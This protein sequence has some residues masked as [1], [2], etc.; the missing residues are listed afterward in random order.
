MVILTNLDP[1]GISKDKLKE[2]V[3]YVK[4]A[5]NAY[6]GK[7]E[8]FWNKIDE[9]KLKIDLLY[10]E[11]NKFSQ[12]NPAGE[13]NEEIEKAIKILEIKQITLYEGIDILIEEM[14]FSLNIDIL[15]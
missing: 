11:Y 3:N 6:K 13:Y 4:E 9:L 14:N 5:I 15:I 8:W 7:I 12:V 10:D 1:A 2:V